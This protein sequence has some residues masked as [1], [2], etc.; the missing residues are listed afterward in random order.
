MKILIVTR[1]H[2]PD[3]RYGLAKSLIPILTEFQRRNIEVG[4]ISQADA[5]ERS[6]AMLR[7]LHHWL[8]KTMGRLFSQ[9]E[10]SA[11]LWGIL[12]RLNM[13]RLAAQVM[14]RERY[15]H[16]HCQDPII[17]TGYRW[18]A[19]I[20]FFARFRRGHTARWGVT[21]HGFGAY[22][23]AIHEDGARLSSRTMHWLRNWETKILLKAHWVI[24]PTQQG[25]Q[26]L[27]RD[28]AIY[29][30]PNTWHSIPHACPILKHYPKA[31]ARQQLAWKANA[32]YLLAVGRFTLL[33]QFPLLIQ[34]CAL[35]QHPNW[36]LVLVGEGDKA[37]LQT[38]AVELGIAERVI[39]TVSDDMGLYYSAA[40]IY[41]SISTTEA[42]GLAN[43]EAMCMG[44][45][46]VCTAV[47]GV[48]D[49]VG[50]GAYL[51]PS[52]DKR[53]LI[54]TLQSLL[55]DDNKRREWAERAQ[56]WTENWPSTEK[57]ATAYLA[58]YQGELLPDI[59][60]HFEL[61]MFHHFATWQQTVNQWPVC[62]LPS[63]L[64][65]PKQANILVIAPHPDDEIFGCGGTLALL[66]QQ[67]CHIKVVVV[68]DGQA[69]DPLDYLDGK[70]VA[71]H[72]RQETC[73][74]LAVLGIDD[75]VFLHHADGHY[76]HSEK[77]HT[78]FDEILDTFRTDWLFLPS[79]LDYHRDHVAVSLSMLAVWQQ[80]G[81]H[82][83]VFFYE[84]WAPIPASWVV[85]ISAVF[86]LK[87]QAIH[88]YQLSLKYCNYERFI[89]GM[90]MYRSLYL[91]KPHYAEAF[92]ELEATSW[93]KTLEHLVNLRQ[94]LSKID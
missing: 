93:Q 78:E 36:Q 25:L 51:I 66:R 4:Y 7:T 76:Q 27:A 87:R 37:T 3:K 28:L 79:V 54:Y 94:R 61:P 31:E 40:D 44:L 85:D 56:Q 92:M 39:F 68:T 48:P 34:A 50:N 71:T 52:Q 5:G 13:G 47:G 74:A 22:T 83:R 15:T 80:R 55:D 30:V 72:R 43:L 88:C 29:P 1:E 10:F 26:Q 41:V 77:S 19:R 84:I 42:F 46:T 57:I 62:P 81:W 35:L 20:R 53:A 58:L 17:A 69:G 38:L 11:L 60:P 16:V 89:E 65:L 45:P 32:V 33:K 2:T 18:F 12:E 90:A 9:T 86:E 91:A 75:V 70:D 6:I 64:I 67:A 59:S 8:S 21:E 73:K 63:P 49:V 23:Q 14:V 82:E 24:T